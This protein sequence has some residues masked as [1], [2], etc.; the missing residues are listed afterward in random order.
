MTALLLTPHASARVRLA[1]PGSSEPSSEASTFDEISRIGVEGLLWGGGILVGAFLLAV[2]AKRITERAVGSRADGLIARLLGRTAGLGVFGLGVVYALNRVGISIAPLLGIFGLVGLAFAFAFQGI[3]ENFIAGILMSLRR[4]LSPGDQVTTAGFTGTVDDISLRAVELKTYEGERVFV[5]NATVWK[6]SIVNHTVLGPRRTTLAVG[7]D[8]DA[9]LDTATQVIIDAA[10]E[11][12][13]VLNDPAP[14]AY[15]HTFGGSS[16]DID[17]RFW[18]EPQIAVEW[19]VR[20][21]VAKRVKAALDEAGIGIPF[22]QRV[23]TFVNEPAGA[24][25]K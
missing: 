6:G 19:Q 21:A 2:V 23:V 5:P 12:E 4:P 16:I 9:D 22:P 13:G 17:V 24:L 18:H 14:Q 11:V 10:G 20:D 1:Q 8:Y 15:V 7:V 3:L 25:A